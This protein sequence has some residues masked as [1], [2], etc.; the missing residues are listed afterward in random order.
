VLDVPSHDIRPCPVIASTINCENDAN[1]KLVT[2]VLRN[3]SLDDI[4][5]IYL[6]Y[7]PTIWRRKVA[8]I[9][10]DAE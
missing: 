8:L 3:E 2:S 6:V 4:V 1:F 5:R 7:V 10:A 9:V